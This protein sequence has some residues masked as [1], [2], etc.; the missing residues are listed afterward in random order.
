MSINSTIDKFS[1]I[2]CKRLLPFF[3]HRSRFSYA[4]VEEVVNHSE[5]EHSVIREAL[6]HF[7]VKEGLDWIH[8]SDLFSKCGLGSSSTFT[9][10]LVYLLF[11]LNGSHP[12][13]WDVAQQ[14]MHIEQNILEESVGCQDILAAT[15]GGF[16]KFEYQKTG[17]I[18]QTRIYPTASFL[19]QLQAASLLFFTGEHR[20][21]N[22]I[23]SQYVG[24]LEAKL[25]HQLQMIE[26]AKEGERRSLERILKR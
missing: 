5:I 12:N 1:W 25:E 19:D 26:L 21:S 17:Q 15:F 22:D 3:K 10:C 16:N 6:R 14:A 4:K 18:L 11:I 9:V 2:S 7:D 24:G 20:T 23:T 8:Q 13:K